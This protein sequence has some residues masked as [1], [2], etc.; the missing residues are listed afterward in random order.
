MHGRI[1]L[2][3]L[4]LAAPPATW[5]SPI[6]FDLRAPLVET[7][8]GAPALSLTLEAL[9]ARVN[10]ASGVLNRTASGFGVNATGGGDDTD[11]IDGALVDEAVSVTFD[12][13]VLLNGIQVSG[14]ARSDS[15]LLL[16]PDLR[17]PLATAGFVAAGGALL[18]R[19]ASF[20]VAHGAGNGFSFDGFL[21]TPRTTGQ[22]PSPPTLPLALAGLLT[23][24]WLRRGRRCCHATSAG[25]PSPRLS[26]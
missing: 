11:A 8:D 24:L 3:I 5:A 12:A 7:L 13:D 2:L 9:T 15:G 21:V 25:W 16:L 20:Q 10:T 19:G 22:V 1:L 14:L 6:F 18:L 17:V 26:R 4:T 23:M